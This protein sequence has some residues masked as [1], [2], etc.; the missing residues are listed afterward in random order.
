MQNMVVEL[1]KKI[2]EENK[3]STELKIV[4][5]AAHEEIRVLKEN[6]Q[7]LYRQFD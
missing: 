7:Q 1:E 4:I 5:Q 2:V 6:E 3:V